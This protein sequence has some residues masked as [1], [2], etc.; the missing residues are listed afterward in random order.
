MP[1]IQH[2]NGSRLKIK[3]DLTL[4]LCTSRP[5]TSLLVVSVVSV[6][7]EEVCQKECLFAGNSKHRET[8]AARDPQLCWDP[9]N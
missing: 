5:G 9:R 3:I 7:R 1:R 8:A 2:M 6:V 4:D